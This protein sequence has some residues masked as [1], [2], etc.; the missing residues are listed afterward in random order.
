MLMAAEIAS[1]GD[2][3]RAFEAPYLDKYTAPT[4]RGVDYPS[5]GVSQAWNNTATG[6]LTVSTYAAAPERRGSQ[7]SWEVTN[8]P[9]TASVSVRLG[10]Q[11]FNRFEVTGPNTIRLD[12]TIEAHQFEITTGYRG[13]GTRQAQVPESAPAGPGLAAA[14]T[15]AAAGRDRP[16]GPDPFMGRPGC[17]CCASE[18]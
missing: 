12:T 9:S 18:G 14:S 13:P 8:L 3:T 11:P 5:L 1:P 6:I 4:V 16:A 2:W 10:G 15:L 17:P 7:T